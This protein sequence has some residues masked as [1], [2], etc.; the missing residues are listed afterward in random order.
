MTT[1]ADLAAALATALADV[2]GVRVHTYPP[3]AFQ[4]PG[5]VIGLPTLSWEGERTFEAL[6]WEFPISLI[7]PRLTDRQVVADLG[8]LLTAVAAALGEDPTLGGVAEYSRLLDAS[9]TAITVGSTDLPGYTV[10]VQI[11]A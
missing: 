1:G 6:N 3:D 9:P 4:P 5:I 8:A 2:E 11:L 10:R 7:V